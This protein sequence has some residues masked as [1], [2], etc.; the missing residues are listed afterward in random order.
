MAFIKR[1]TVAM[2]LASVEISSAL[3]Q[4]ERVQ[5]PEGVRWES[6]VN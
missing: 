1:P 2:K 5:P 3:V 4:R 6:I